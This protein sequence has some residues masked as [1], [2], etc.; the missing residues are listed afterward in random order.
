MSNS[1]DDTIPTIDLSVEF[2]LAMGEA[3]TEAAT[4]HCTKCHALLKHLHKH[5]GERKFMVVVDD[6]TMLSV[7]RL[8]ELLSW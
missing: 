2:D 3:S 1:A 7:D 6:D 4:G 8:L 5:Y